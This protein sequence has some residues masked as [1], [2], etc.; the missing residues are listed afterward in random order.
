MD[1]FYSEII[2]YIDAIAKINAFFDIIANVCSNFSVKLSYFKNLLVMARYMFCSFWS[3]SQCVA[4]KTEV[5]T[6]VGTVGRRAVEIDAAKFT[7]N[8]N[9]LFLSTSSG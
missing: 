4:Q 6:D 8:A 3:T 9:T 7:D 2:V 5:D 1:V